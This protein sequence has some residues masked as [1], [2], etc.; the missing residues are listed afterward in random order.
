MRS[1]D[2]VAM[3]RR[4]K[5]RIK[6]GKRIQPLPG[7]P[8]PPPMPQKKKKIKKKR[9]K[10]KSKIKLLNLKSSTINESST[11]YNDMVGW[12]SN[13]SNQT[14]L[15]NNEEIK[16]KEPEFIKHQCNLC[17]TIMKVPK[18]KKSSYTIICPHCEHEEKFG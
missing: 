6:K 8:L 10:F 7:M 5:T 4:K 18:A 13:S 14:I 17:G 1:S 3:K 11:E 9:F 2:T 15:N 12:T 16:Q